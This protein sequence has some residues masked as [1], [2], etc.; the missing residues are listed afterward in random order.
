MSTDEF[1]KD[2]T[3]NIWESMKRQK[4]H[5]NLLD[6]I[7]QRRS[8]DFGWYDNEKNILICNCIDSKVF[9]A[10]YSTIEELKADFKKNRGFKKK[11][12]NFNW[13]QPDCSN[14]YERLQEKYSDLLA[15]MEQ[16]F[17]ELEQ[18]AKK[19]PD[20]QLYTFCYSDEDGSFFSAMEHGNIFQNFE[21]FAESHH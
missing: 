1:K 15:D 3:H 11:L 7:S 12:E 9:K 10:T 8:Y 6:A 14:K 20:T 13:D 19:Y 18:N 2:A 17:T 4:K 21:G 5:K 16:E